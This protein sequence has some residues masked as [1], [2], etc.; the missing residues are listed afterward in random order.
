M[1][2]MNE[3]E[4]IP[5]GIT[6]GVVAYLLT[7][8]VFKFSSTV[9][10][11]TAILVGYFTMMKGEFAISDYFFK[12]WYSGYKKN[13]PTRTGAGFKPGGSLSNLINMDTMNT[14]TSD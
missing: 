2:D 11:G 6:S 9:S 1:S 14:T 13:M 7:D 5:Y 3:L 12:N 10:I 8:R 4:A